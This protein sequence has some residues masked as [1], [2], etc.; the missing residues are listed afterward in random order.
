MNVEGTS[1]IDAPKVT[2]IL[3]CYSHE[4]Y[5]I[6][7]V[8]SILVQT[9][10]VECIILNNG[11]NAQYSE[12]IRQ[13]ADTHALKVVEVHPN[14]YGLGLRALVLPH[15]ETEFVAILHDDDVYMPR[16][17]ER[18]LAALAKSEADYVVT[19]S[20][21][22]DERGG[23]WQGRNEA[24]NHTQFDGSETCGEL[25]ADMVRPPGCRMHFSTLVMRTELAKRSVLGDP[26][27]PRIADAVFWVNLLMDESLKLEI[28]PEYLSKVRIHSANDRLY[29]KFAEQERQKHTFLL[30]MSEIELVGKVLRFGSPKIVIEFLS[31]F[32]GFEVGPDLISALVMTA[33]VMEKSADEY[34]ISKLYMINILIHRAVEIDFMKTCELVEQMSGRDANQFMMQGYDRFASMVLGMKY[35][36]LALPPPPPPTAVVPS[37]QLEPAPPQLDPAVL[38]SMPG[39][40]KNYREATVSF[41]WLWRHPKKA[42]ARGLFNVA[43]KIGRQTT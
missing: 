38:S 33:A 3:C 22:I 19:N 27:W 37:P 29:D 9:V 15:V 5:F 41:R 42:V 18:S 13:M 10:P 28:L 7:A 4:K 43:Q 6:P 23:P 8:Q 16:K 20:L 1:T 11:A 21:L 34:W 24:V 36:A 40:I 17:I 26:F 35:A 12:L 30:A 31:S 2:V 32:I 14:T 39:A 25:I